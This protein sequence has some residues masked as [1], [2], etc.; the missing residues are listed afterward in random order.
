MKLHYKR[1]ANQ[2]VE[3][4]P[5]GNGS[6]GAMVFG[7]VDD[8]KLQLNEDTLWSGYPKEWNNPQA[9]QALPEIRRLIAN[10]QY[11]EA[12]QLSKSSMMGPYTQTYMPLGNLHLS[13]YH[14]NLT[15]TYERE[16]NLEHGIAR[17]EYTIG[18]VVYTREMF[19]SYPD[20]VLV[21]RLSSSQP[22]KLSC[23]ATLNS[24]LLSTVVAEKDALVLRGVCPENVDPSYYHT[25]D[26]VIYGKP[27]STKAMRFEGRL[28]AQMM[29]DEGQVHI[30][31][32]GLHV[33]RATEVVLLFSASTSFNG[34]DRVPG[35]DGKDPGPINQGRLQKAA[36]KTIADLLRAHLTD[37]Q[38]LFKRVQLSL[39]ESSLP[40]STP[41]NVRI[42]TE[43]ANDP[44]LVE[45]LFQ[46]GRYLLIAGSRPGTQPLNLQGIWSH[47]VRPV[48]SSNYTLNINA[49]MNYWPAETT[50]LS[51]CHQPLLQF[52][53]ELAENGRRTAEINYGCGG[54]TA[55]HNSDL[56]RQTAPPGDYGHG[57]PLWANWP[58]GGIWLCQHLWEHHAFQDNLPYLRDHAYPIM[59]A[60][61]QFCLDWLLDDE[62]GQWMTSPS[63]SPE[64]RFITADGQKAALSEMTTMDIM[65]IR[66][67]FTNCIRAAERLEVDASLQE[68]WER[69]MEQLPSLQIGKHGQL[70]EW[71]SDFTDADMHHRH[72]SH[73]YGL[74]PGAELLNEENDAFRK[75]AQTT[76]ERRGDGGTGWSLAW[77]AALWARLHD[78]DRA[79]KLIENLLCPTSGEDMNFKDSG[80]YPNL[81]LAH[82]PFQIDGNFGA[83]AAITEMLIQSHNG[84]IEL[85]PALPKAWSAGAVEGL[86]ARGGFELSLAWSAGQLQSAVIYSVQGGKCFVKV[87]CPFL[88]I[89]VV[90]IGNEEKRIKTERK[91]EQ[92]W[93]W[94]TEAGH[95]YQIKTT[96]HLSKHPSSSR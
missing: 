39:G 69:T 93:C 32:D 73:L 58:M 85:L 31:Q 1:P 84:L 81:F 66:E 40:E 42:V 34:F 68:V 21:V 62:R 44:K 71:L 91:D 41:T 9:K 77:K 25:D 26:P 95:R 17:V 79:L 35:T 64:H 45:L 50:H 13:F 11:L 3:A 87:A 15:K 74:Y 59:K 75:A 14:G 23:K 61:A 55:H 38:A 96:T 65:L 92:T 72:V 20:Q 36:N 51:E 27:E 46:Y 60:A 48:W 8:E 70:Q 88:S 53:K 83:T 19:I 57:N 24:P 86:R 10:G 12:E 49:Q 16:L 63:T 94:M 37:H 4:L 56:W 67:L 7:G 2:W 89:R 6:L 18:R 82:P 33:D 76:L 29:T 22:G 54:W 78:G 52:I 5:L 30:D 28:I 47:E 80:V 43:G 90:R